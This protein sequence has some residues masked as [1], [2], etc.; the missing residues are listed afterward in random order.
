M[1][2]VGRK[3]NRIFEFN[4]KKDEEI[5]S[6]GPS[7]KELI[8]KSNGVTPLLSKKVEKPAEVKETQKAAYRLYTDNPESDNMDDVHILSSEE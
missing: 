4:P 5:I 8:E 1:S 6:K 7:K 2:S 3:L